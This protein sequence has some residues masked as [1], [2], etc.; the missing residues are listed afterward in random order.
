MWRT[1]IRYRRVHRRPQ[2]AAD[3]VGRGGLKLGEEDH[4]QVLGRVDKEGGR[5]GAAPII[6]AGRADKLGAGLVEEHRETKAETDAVA[7]RLARSVSVHRRQ[8]AA[9][10]QVV[11]G[12]EPEGAGSEDALT[13]ELAT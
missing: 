12:H 9:A 10:G 5:S 2:L 7:R 1:S 11:D 4:D 13:I 8:I 6:F 3:R